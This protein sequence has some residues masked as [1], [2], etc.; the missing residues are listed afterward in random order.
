MVTHIEQRSIDLSIMEVA[1]IIIQVRYVIQTLWDH[2]IQLNMDS[3][4]IF[5]SPSVN[6]LY[7]AK[8]MEPLLNAYRR[9]SVPGTKN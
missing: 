1:S 3:V 6:Y 8:N 4:L 5:L 2:N 9:E 7:L